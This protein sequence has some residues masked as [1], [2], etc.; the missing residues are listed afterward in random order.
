[1]LRDNTLI[2]SINEKTG[3]VEWFKTTPV[4]LAQVNHPEYYKLLLII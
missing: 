2:W 3:E 1:M 4:G